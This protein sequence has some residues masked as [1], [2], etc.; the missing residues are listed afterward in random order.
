MPLA[1]ILKAYNQRPKNFLPLMLDINESAGLSLRLATV[2]GMRLFVV[3]PSEAS[4]NWYWEHWLTLLNKTKYISHAM[5]CTLLL[6]SYYLLLTSI[7][8]WTTLSTA[9]IL[10]EL[11]A[12]RVELF[13]ACLTLL[14]R[15]ALLLWRNILG[16]SCMINLLQTHMVF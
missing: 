15:T 5:V 4:R 16:H 11:F 3:M 9:N 1:S 12:A 6:A 7:F 8:S 13:L 14:V 2:T 10:C